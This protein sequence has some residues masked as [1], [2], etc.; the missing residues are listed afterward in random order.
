[1]SLLSKQRATVNDTYHEEPCFELQTQCSRD[2]DLDLLRKH[3]MNSYQPDLTI[4]RDPDE[5]SRVVTSILVD[6]LQ[7]V[8]SG[9][10]DRFISCRLVLYLFVCN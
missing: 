3:S 8:V 7:V 4:T 10:Q 1:M 6:D 2:S 9:A 5:P